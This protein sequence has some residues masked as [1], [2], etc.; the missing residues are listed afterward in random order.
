MTEKERQMLCD[1]FADIK[2]ETQVQYDRTMSEINNRQRV[3]SGKIQDQLYKW[4]LE[5]DEM[6]LRMNSLIS[7]K[8]QLFIEMKKLEH[9][10]KIDN[11][12]FHSLKHMLAENNPAP[13]GGAPA[14]EAE[15]ETQN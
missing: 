15:A 3:N 11:R 8:R 12:L 10:Q 5:M 4:S 1:E 14:G 7:A 6:V 9:E 13:I 2:C